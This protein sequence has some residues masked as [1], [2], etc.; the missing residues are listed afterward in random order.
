[1]MMKCISREEGIQLL[2]DIHSGICVSHSSSHSIIDKV[3]RHGFDW[4]ISRDDAMEIVTRC[5]DCQF[6]QKKTIK[7]V[8]PLR[9]IDHRRMKSKG[10]MGYNCLHHNFVRCAIIVYSLIRV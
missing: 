8:N 6:F 4:P 5:R 9:P 10:V 1:M 2:H 7:H 3:F